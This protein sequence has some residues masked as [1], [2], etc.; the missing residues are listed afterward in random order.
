MNRRLART[1]IV[2]LGFAAL[3]AAGAACANGSTTAAGTPTASASH[4]MEHAMAPFGSACASVPASGSGS[5]EMQM[6]DPAA[7]AAAANPM[8][9]TL[10]HA[11]MQAK[12]T[13]TLNASSGITVFAPT[14]AAFSSMNPDALMMAMH[15]PQGELTK[16]LTYHVVQ[17]QLSPAQLTGT[18]TTLEGSTIRVTGSGENFVVNGTAHVVCGDI[19]ASNA[20]IYMINGVLTPP[21]S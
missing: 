4:P 19:H 5:F 15:D 9:A 16:I 20:T 7:S 11:L 18:H 13:D 3:A 6:H 12:L 21:T 2:A 10:S 14:N 8:L 1:G 17:G